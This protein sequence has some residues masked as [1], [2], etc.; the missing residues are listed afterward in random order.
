MRKIQL[1]DTTLRDGEQNKGINYTVEDK[2]KIAQMLDDYGFDYIEG[3]WP[4]SNPKSV[5]FFERMQTVTLKHAKLVAFGSTRHAKLTSAD[6][7]SLQAILATK[8]SIACVF[9]KS[10][11]LHVMHALNVSLEVNLEMIFD[12]VKY[13]KDNG[14]RVIYDAEH[15]F[16]GYKNN[17]DYA[18]K[19]LIAAKNAGADT[20]ALCDTNGGTLPNEIVSIITEIK[21]HIN[22]PLGIHAHDDSG[23]AV[24][25]S[26]AAV[27]SGITQIQG[28]INGFGERCGNANF[29]SIIPILQLKMGIACISADKLKEL[30]FLSRCIYEI[31]NL[32]PCEQMPYVGKNAFAHKAGVHVNAVMKNPKTYEH[33]QPELVGNKHEVTV[34]ELSG[35]GNLIYVADKLG[36]IIDKDN[37]KIKELLQYI[38]NLENFGYAFEEGEA[39]LELLLHRAIGKKHTF[40]TLNKFRII[41]EKNSDTE[42]TVV[43]A[44][45]KIHVNNNDVYTSAEGSGPIDALEKALLQSLEE[46]YPMLKTVRITNYKVRILNNK[47]GLKSLVRVTVEATDGKSIWNTVGV[48]SD[49][50]EASWHAISDSIEYKLS[51]SSLG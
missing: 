22:I 42:E 46:I 32:I 31:A 4:G 8:A 33:I 6:D 20:I 10:W 45:I 37:P 11:D 36:I 14:L 47:E 27:E 49:I 1:Y 26:I 19:T 48:S 30:T 9:G 23:M 7:P 3:G 28:T 51:K 17:P 24:A 43:E 35:I 5:E 21:K 39:S 13:L 18:I 50:I 2:I 15:C 34:S 16:D 44:A 12:T 38:K 25:N 29:C 40:Y 41:S